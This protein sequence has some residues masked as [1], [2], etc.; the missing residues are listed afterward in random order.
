MAT[1]PKDQVVQVIVSHDGLNVGERFR[2]NSDNIGWVTPRVE[3]G[4]LALFEG[5]D[6]SVAVSPQD[7]PEPAPVVE[8]ER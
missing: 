8:S 7:Q 2:V 1:N 3:A 4:Y 6:W 5:S